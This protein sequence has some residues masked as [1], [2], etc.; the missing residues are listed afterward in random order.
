[1]KNFINLNLTRG[2][3]I[4]V[5]IIDKVSQNFLHEPNVFFFDVILTIYN[6]KI[7]IHVN[8]LFKELLYNFFVGPLVYVVSVDTLGRKR[9]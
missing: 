5:V 1:M 7:Y 6:N 9:K 4:L 2:R 3:F 8:N